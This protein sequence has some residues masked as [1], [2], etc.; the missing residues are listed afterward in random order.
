M[1]DGSVYAVLFR[2][3]EFKIGASSNPVARISEAINSGKSFGYALEMVFITDS[4]KA[5]GSTKERLA[6]YCEERFHATDGDFFNGGD[7]SSL[8]EAM[9][10]TK[11]LVTWATSL[12]SVGG[13]K[14]LLVPVSSFDISSQSCVSDVELELMKDKIMSIVTKNPGITS[15]VIKNR[16][17]KYMPTVVDDVLLAMAEEGIL[18]M[19]ETEHGHTGAK[20]L[21][22]YPV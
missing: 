18:S 4:H 16:M 19:V 15:G 2:T 22:F 14:F 6:E 11:R 1:K 3:G 7:V 8:R 17:R 10:S 9:I 20:V 13:N 21:K 12:Q 5:A